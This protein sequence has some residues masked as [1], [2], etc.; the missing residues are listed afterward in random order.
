MKTVLNL[1]FLVFICFH[2]FTQ[3]KPIL[4]FDETKKEFDKNSISKK[5]LNLWAT[6]YYVPMLQHNE[7]GIDLL[8]ADEEKTGL[9]LN[10]SDWCNSAIQGTVII[11]KENK[12][13]VLNFAR[14]SKNLQFDCRTCSKYKNYDG[15]LKTG[16]VLWKKSEGFGTGVNNYK[17]VPFKSIAVDKSIIPY[18]SIVYIDQAKGIKYVDENGKFKKH[19][20]YFFAADTGSKISGNHIDVFIG[21]ETKNPFTFI[22]SNS[23]K[24]FEAYIINDG[25]F[26]IKLEELHKKI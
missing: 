2:C 21:T 11:K 4:E 3:S 15:Y 20:G 9:K 26:K 23:K 16:K 22:K 8:N 19:N 24:T 5:K 18:G 7:N 25:K 17:L 6:Y 10:S 14:R 1:I 13:Y 12:T